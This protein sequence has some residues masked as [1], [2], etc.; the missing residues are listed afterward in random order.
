MMSNDKAKPSD[1]K[2]SYSSDKQRGVNEGGRGG[3]G[4]CGPHQQDRKG[5]L[6][7]TGGGIEV[8]GLQV[9]T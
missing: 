9:L 7:Y 2:I 8:H 1:K 3:E 4:G 5:S 6:L